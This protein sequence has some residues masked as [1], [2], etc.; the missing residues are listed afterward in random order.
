MMYHWYMT[1]ENIKVFQIYIRNVKYKKDHF[2]M[3]NRYANLEFAYL[4]IQNLENFGLKNSESE[5]FK[6]NIQMKSEL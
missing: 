6:I 4:R 1:Q 2:I 5:D 3:F